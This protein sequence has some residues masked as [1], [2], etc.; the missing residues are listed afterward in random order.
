M[1]KIESYLENI[2]YGFLLSI[3]PVITISIADLFLGHLF[4]LKL[5]LL[6]IIKFGGI[7]LIISVI[8][9]HLSKLYQRFIWIILILYYIG[10]IIY[11]IANIYFYS[12]GPLFG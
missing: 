2:I 12:I 7:G 8:Y 11:I 5:I 10:W 3:A 6:E 4:T 1:N 9:N